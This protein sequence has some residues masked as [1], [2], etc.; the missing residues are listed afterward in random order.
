MNKMIK[1]LLNKKMLRPLVL[2]VCGIII[3]FFLPKMISSIEGFEVKPA[4]LDSQLSGGKKLVLFYAD[5]CGH[6]KKFKPVWDE[7]A[8][9][10]NTDGQQKLVKVNVGDSSEESEK[11]MK[12]Y[13]VD[14]FP[15]I[16]LVDKSGSNNEINIY[17][18]ERTKES[19]EEYVNSK[20]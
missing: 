13:K 15:T 11:I 3:M 5:W 1:K 7:V 8:G 2:V 10:V 18:G 12:D 17:E 4:E 19:L 14:G 9:G 16:V 6:C 20:L